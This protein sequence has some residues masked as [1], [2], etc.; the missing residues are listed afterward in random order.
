M[1]TNLKRVRSSLRVSGDAAAIKGITLHVASAVLGKE[2]IVKTD[3]NGVVPG[4]AA[5]DPLSP[6]NGQPVFDTLAIAV[7]RTTTRSSWPR[8]SW[9][10]PASPT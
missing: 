1:Q 10:S 6:L 9:T 8:A 4:T 3:D 5:P 2:L 7:S